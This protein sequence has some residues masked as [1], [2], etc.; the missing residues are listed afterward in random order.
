[1]RMS[2]RPV[3]KARKTK[4][5]VANSPKGKYL[6]CVLQ[7]EVARH[8]S[9][10]WFNVDVHTTR[11]GSLTSDDGTGKLIDGNNEKIE[12][13]G[14][15]EI[16]LF[17]V[18]FIFCENWKKEKSIFLQATM[19]RKSHMFSVFC[20]KIKLNKTLFCTSGTEVQLYSPF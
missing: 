18:N 4:I 14:W 20:M 6:L 19:S 7:S 12:K 5:A 16:R 11:L 2:A 8:G 3:C 9:A 17:T 1:M 10:P 13:V 15:P